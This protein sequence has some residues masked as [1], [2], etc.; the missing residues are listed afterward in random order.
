MSLREYTALKH[1]EA[2]NTDFSKKLLSGEISKEMY[3]DY[4]Y[5]LT[6]IYSGIEYYADLLGFFDNMSDLK[7]TP[8]IFADF[9]ELAGHSFS[10]TWKKTTVDYYYYLQQLYKNPE[11][12]HL[13]IAHVYVRHMGDLFGGQ[14]ISK[15]VPGSHTFYQFENRSE[16]ISKIRAK[17]NDN[18]GD[19]ANIAFDWAIKLMKEY[20]KSL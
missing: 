17:L 15:K 6:L 14:M 8:A 4:L 3:A 20:D 7:R 18:L 9:I 13:I 19:E 2:E 5:Q 11:T 1:H 16:L 12:K 10:N